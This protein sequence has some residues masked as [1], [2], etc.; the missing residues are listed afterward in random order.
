VV[1]TFQNTSATLTPT[2]ASQQL[3]VPRGWSARATS[4][5]TA[6]SL[7]PGASS[8]TSWSVTAPAD[9]AGSSALLTANA[10]WSEHGAPTGGFATTSWQL[11]EVDCATSQVCELAQGTLA[12]GAC[13][14]SNH[15]G[16]TGPPGFVA[17]FDQGPNR[18][19]SQQVE[20]ASAGSYNVS[21]RYSAGPNG[22]TGDRT[23][24]VSVNGGPPHVVTLPETGSW[25]TWGNVATPLQLNAG[26]NTIT[27]SDPSGTTGWVNLDSIVVS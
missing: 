5:T 23:M 12:G 8:S 22:P 9:S 10:T 13:I 16:Y 3:N 6:A 4:P 25:D 24:A 17:C 14:A 7:A 11:G 2:N 20:V 1:T 26:S 15:T 19:A 27:Y 18:S 21:L